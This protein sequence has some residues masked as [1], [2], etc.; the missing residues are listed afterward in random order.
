MGAEGKFR[1]GAEF[2]A[3]WFAARVC[4]PN[5]GAVF[6]RIF[7]LLLLGIVTISAAADLPQRY[8]IFVT[9]DGMRWQEVFGGADEVLLDKDNGGV[10]DVPALRTQF[11]ADTPEERRVK[12]MP[13]FWTEIASKGQIY[14]NRT[15]GSLA[16]V[17]NGLNFSYPGYNEFLS[18]HAD[19]GIRSNKAVPNPNVTVLEWLQT[20]PGF[21]GRV[22]AFN[23][24]HTLTA[25]LNRD[26]S[27]LPMWTPGAPNAA[28]LAFPRKAELEALVADLVPP[29]PEEH[30]DAFVFAGAMDYLRQNRPRVMYVNFGETDEW[31][32]A[33]RYDRYLLAAHH[34]DRWLK[35]LWETAQSIPE[36]KGRTSL[37]VTTDHGR[38]KLPE[39]WT[40]HGEKITESGETWIA[41][42]GP[43]TPALG[44]RSN[45]GPVKQ[46]QVAATV[47]RLVGEDYA[48]AE[49]KAA[50]AIG[51]V[52]NR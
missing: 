11:W 4:G 44:E 9:T 32:H 24:W 17:T 34:V 35:A 33:R 3:I 5:T 31:A 21:G 49:P 22:V 10:T 23:A 45:V 30:F 26:R 43:D 12:L 7:Y 8:V 16:N 25:I 39:T 19:P 40:S 29:W 42:M 2:D 13:Y 15:K 46:A 18:G 36:M 6:P 1:C 27:R 47:A 14:G 50:G 51:E 41:V 52:F 28:D 38:G 48:G 37:V 20:R